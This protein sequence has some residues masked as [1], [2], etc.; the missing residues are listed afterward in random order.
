MDILGYFHGETTRRMREIIF[1]EFSKT[2]NYG[3]IFTFMWAF[4]QQSDWDYIEHVTKMFKDR[5][6]DV[7]YIELFS[8]QEI[9]LLRNST[10]NR[11]K[12]K[13]SKRDIDTSNQRLINDDKN[14]RC[15]SNEGEI[16]F[17]NHMRIDNSKTSAKDVAKRIKD[18][19]KL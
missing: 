16:K 14:Y 8:P 10:E 17:D 5:G 3:L 2:D 6:A 18:N 13:T 15:V 12:N 19:F 11:L 9:R 7:Y 4:D 1:Q